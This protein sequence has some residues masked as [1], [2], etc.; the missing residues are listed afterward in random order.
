[1]NIQEYRQR[2]EETYLG[3]RPNTGSIKPAHVANGLF[4]GLTGKR[5]DTERLYNLIYTGN[6][7]GQIAK[8]KHETINVY[9][10][11]KDDKLID[12]E[13]ININDF[14]LFRKMARKVLCADGAVFTE[15][16]I[17]FSAGHTNAIGRDTIGQDGGELIAYA[18][19]KLCPELGETITTWLMDDS[20]L[21][22]TIA[23]PTFSDTL[24]DY[25][26]TI[27]LEEKE[28]F[29]LNLDIIKSPYDTFTK[30][31]ATAFKTINKH[32]QGEINKLT[33]LRVVILFG[34][35]WLI[36]QLCSAEGL[37]SDEEETKIF[38]LILDFSEESSESIA[39]ASM[40][41]YTLLCQ[42]LARFYAEKIGEFL[43]E[44]F[45]LDALLIEPRPKY[46]EKDK[47]KQ[48]VT[49]IWNMA[50]EDAKGSVGLLTEKGIYTIFGA[51]IYDILALEASS[52]PVAS[53]RSLGI[54]S[55]LFYPP[56]N[57]PPTK[58]FKPSQDTFEAI[59]RATV[60][61]GIVI[62]INTLK[63]RL[64]SRLGLVVG[65][66]PQDEGIL[67]NAGLY[68]V[69][70][71]ALKENSNNFIK[72]LKELDFARIMADGVLEIRLGV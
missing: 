53:M 36:R 29:Y 15:S 60:D 54:R 4:K 26:S 61:P 3:F 19:K 34:C 43:S 50:I 13:V 17:S 32:L 30:E 49:D 47:N 16:M 40:M 48:A 38:P 35:Y 65:G 10:D 69:D 12:G 52:N 9:N 42:S 27:N 59:M 62:D 23:L 57:N 41:N 22:S 33:G 39:K 63:D 14:A 68:Q 6:A 31:M 2:V 20:D 55:G 72:W 71:D 46:N 44:D 45:S 7:K 58:R 51:A 5:A 28:K 67:R 21:I 24:K 64:W 1:M 70:R 56:S 11:F 25:D 18:I 37:Y 8:K 66:R